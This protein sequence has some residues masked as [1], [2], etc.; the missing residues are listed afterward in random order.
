MTVILLVYYYKY[1]KN[2]NIQ[3]IVPERYRILAKYDTP[4]RKGQI[5]TLGYATTTSESKMN[6]S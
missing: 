2:F 1:I 3:A 4:Y 6:N 5:H